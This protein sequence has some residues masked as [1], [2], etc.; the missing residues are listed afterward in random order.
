MQKDIYLVRGLPGAGKTTAAQSLAREGDTLINADDF[1]VDEQG[2]YLFKGE[3][4]PEVH[5][6]CEREAEDAMQREVPR[7]FVHNT[8]T[9]EW[10]LKPYQ[11]LA[12]KYG[13]RMFSLIVE[14]R[15]GGG[16]I[17]GALPETIEAMRRRF[18]I[19]L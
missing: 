1:M 5:K 3:R 6:A 16:N 10:E 2:N 7:I 8:L 9:Q 18:E 4:L 19:Q 17:H 14:N 12:Q 15:H 11:E 13:Y